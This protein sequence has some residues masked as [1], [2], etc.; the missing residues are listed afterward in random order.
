MHLLALPPP[1][2][3]E[4]HPSASSTGTLG[5][6]RAPEISFIIKCPAVELLTRLFPFASLIGTRSVSSHTDRRPWKNE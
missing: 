4:I 6:F 5:P 3:A 2:P 1:P